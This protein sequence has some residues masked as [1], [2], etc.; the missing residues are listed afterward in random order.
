MHIYLQKK[1]FFNFSLE[2]EIK[3]KFTPNICMPNIYSI[4]LTKKKTK[5]NHIFYAIKLQN[6]LPNHCRKT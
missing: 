3:N 6:P 1:M 2:L 4:I 5:L